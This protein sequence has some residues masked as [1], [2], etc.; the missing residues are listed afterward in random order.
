[1]LRYF[2]HSRPEGVISHGRTPVHPLAP[3]T[4]ASDSV[5]SPPVEDR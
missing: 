4:E 3:R 1:M 5:E 2:Y